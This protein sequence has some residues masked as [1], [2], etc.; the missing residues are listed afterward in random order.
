MND[1]VLVGGLAT[2]ALA[3]AALASRGRGLALF[4]ALF[5]LAEAVGGLSLL[6]EA[7]A[8]GVLSFEKGAG[9]LVAT[10]VMALAWSGLA[11]LVTGRLLGTSEPSVRLRLTPLR[12]LGVVAAYIVLYFVAGMLA[13]PHVSAYYA[14]LRLPG[15]GE[16]LALQT[17]RALLIAGAVVPLM[18]LGLR[19]PEVVVGLLLAVVGGIA[20]LSGSS[21]GMPEAVRMVHAVEVGISNFLFGVVIA[22]LLKPSAQEKAPAVAGEGQSETAVNQD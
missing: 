1:L 4:I 13:Y 15:I 11:V 17:A 5:I 18:R 6:I 3:V 2:G 20:P 10:T 21:G 9:A 22:W 12:L 16:L 8:F 7:V 19:Y 14:D